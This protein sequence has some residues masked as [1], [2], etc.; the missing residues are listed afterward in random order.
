M[1]AQSQTGII[2]VGA[3]AYAFIQAE[4]ATNGG[5]IVGEEGVIIVEALMTKALTEQ[6][7]AE[8]KKV[9]S[10][11]IRSVIATH[12]HGD[13]TFGNQYYLPASILGHAECRDEL[14]EKWDLSVERFASRY[15]DTDPVQAAEFRNARITPPDVVFHNEKMTLY[16]GNKRIELYYFGKAHTR[17]DILTYLPDDKLMYA[18]DVAT[19]AGAP[20]TMDGYPASWVSV[21]EKLEALD[22]ETIVPGHG[23]VGDKG[24]ATTEREFLAGL[25]SETRKRLDSGMSVEKAVADITVPGFES[26][27]EGEGFETSVERLYLELRG[28]I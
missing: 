4:G 2:E 3:N 16:L 18:G 7:K 6:V 15:D 23:P 5:F 9:T 22:V 11:P 20:F 13:H 27:S 8:V 21:L 10:L 12:F 19:N 26:W 14:I 1:A 17:G 24:M 25:T 28:Q